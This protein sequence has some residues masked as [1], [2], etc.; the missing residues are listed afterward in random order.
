MRYNKMEN[1]DL[2][3]KTVLIRED[4]NVPIHDGKITSDARL[5]AS[6]QTI[7]QALKQGAG[8]LVMSHLGRPEEGV[9]NEE[10]SLAP[11]AT[12][13]S[14][15]L[16]FDVPL[17]KDWIDGVTVEPGKVKLLENT[18]F[19]VGEGKNNPELAKKMAALC[20]V[21]VMDAFA[22]AHRSAASTVGVGDA[23]KVACAGMVLSQELD[24]LKK[25]LM[26]PE[27]PIVAIVGGSKVSTKLTVLNQLLDKVDVLITGGG[28]TNTLLLA[29][30]FSVGKSLAEA[31]LVAD[32]KALLDKAKATGKNIPLPVDVVVGK[33]F[34]ANTEATVKKIA[35]VSSDDMIM[36]IG[37]ETAKLYAELIKTSKTVVWNGP[38]GVFE[39]A[40]FA[41]GTKAVGDAIKNSQAF[42]IAGGGDTVAAIEQFGLTPSISYISTAGGAFLEFLEG[43]ELPAVAMLERKAN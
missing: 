25:G 41:E 34:D 27:H 24:A 14:D 2:V 19:L 15:K 1:L 16:G 18:R 12:W 35:D 7:E 40:S 4:L 10:Y 38:V 36:D 20:D 5:V 42:S 9:F 33:A 11:V 23:A 30:G 31:D 8:V 13:L 21:F 6:M 32:A 3:G 39:F 29:E 22:T 26:A 17:V 28:I 37:P 43:K